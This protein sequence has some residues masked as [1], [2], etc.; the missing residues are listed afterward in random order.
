MY[1]TSRHADQT[2]KRSL[3]RD[4]VADLPAAAAD[5]DL[6]RAVHERDPV[7]RRRLGG[8]RER[9]V[10]AGGARRQ[11]ALGRVRRARRE[12]GDRRLGHAAEAGRDRASIPRRPHRLAPCRVPHRW[13]HEPVPAADEAR[14]IGHDDVEAGC[15]RVRG[16]FRSPAARR[17]Q[18][19]VLGGDEEVAVADRDLPLGEPLDDVRGAEAGREVEERIGQR[20]H[21][22]QR[23]G[24]EV[25]GRVERRRL[26]VPL[27]PGDDVLVRDLRLR[28]LRRPVVQ[29]G[30]LRQQVGAHLLHQQLRVGRHPRGGQM[31]ALRERPPADR[32]AAAPE[33]VDRRLHGRQRRRQRALVAGVVGGAGPRL[34]DRQADQL[35]RLPAV[36]V[37]EDVEGLDPQ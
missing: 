9:P 28:E 32:R 14:R 3:D 37:D 27:R 12:P 24:P 15:G 1:A 31:A 5:R 21:H 29:L 30:D 20:R 6:R 23:P 34:V 8:D 11:E 22:Q 17:R 16:H 35:D 4:G 10:P 13:R 26:T 19:R 36:G 2:P 18:L 7:G 33:P 25:G